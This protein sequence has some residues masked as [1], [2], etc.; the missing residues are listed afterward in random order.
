M[1]AKKNFLECIKLR[2]LAN[3]DYKS[4]LNWSRDDSF[5]SANG[6]E[7]IRNSEEELYKW[8]LK[9]VNNVAEDFIRNGNRV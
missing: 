9:C 8:W 6:W 1:D 7:T 3:D 4:V 2:S 5:C